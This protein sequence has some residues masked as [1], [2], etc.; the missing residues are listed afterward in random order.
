MTMFNNDNHDCGTPELFK[1]L[2]EG[3]ADINAVDKNGRNVLFYAANAN[4]L[5]LVKYL[6]S[7]GANAYARD[8]HGKTVVESL[9]P[10]A[11]SNEII[12]IIQSY[13]NR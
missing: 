1:V 3:G 13:Y 6:M 8:S 5:T 2:V 4:D 11:A 9:K 10:G 7:A 12:R